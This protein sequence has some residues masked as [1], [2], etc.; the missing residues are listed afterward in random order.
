VLPAI[1]V[2]VGVL[3]P[4]S[5]LLAPTLVESLAGSQPGVVIEI[6]E[7]TTLDAYL[8]FT[9]DLTQIVLIAVIIASAGMIAGEVRSGTAVLVL[10]KPL[11]RQ[12][13][14]VA[15]VISNSM[16]V[17]LAT[18]LGSL[19]CSILTIALF[20]DALLAEFVEAVA[21][22]LLLALLFVALMALLSAALRSQA[23]AAGAGLVAYL[24]LAIASG[25]GPAREYS[26]AGLVAASGQILTGEAVA[27]VWPVA[28]ATLGVVALTA[29]AAALF[30]RQEL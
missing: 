7:P 13:M 14:V 29:A 19:V 23:G 26:P 11:S 5:A 17:G 3:G 24:L 10:T 16:L 22:W 1:L 15:K 6:P 4:V 2:A 30:A 12:A 9:G 28:T 27:L 21:V 20:D 18:V 25:W 8:Q